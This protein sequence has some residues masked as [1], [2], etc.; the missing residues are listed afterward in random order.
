MGTCAPNTFSEGDLNNFRPQ[1]QPQFDG[2]QK[3]F[4]AVA[5]ATPD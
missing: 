3:V 4:G 5:I 2:S 1:N